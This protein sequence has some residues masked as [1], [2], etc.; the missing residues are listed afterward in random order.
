MLVRLGERRLWVYE[1]TISVDNPLLLS[2][3]Y[4]FASA[5]LLRPG[6]KAASD[7][8][9]LFKEIQTSHVFFSSISES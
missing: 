4:Y 9:D 3:C 8:N 2:V 5:L 1:P 7:N 6:L